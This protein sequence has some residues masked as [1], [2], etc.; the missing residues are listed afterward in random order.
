LDKVDRRR[1]LL[2]NRGVL[3]QLAQLGGIAGWRIR[4]Q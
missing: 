1:G 2:D 3:W 4:E